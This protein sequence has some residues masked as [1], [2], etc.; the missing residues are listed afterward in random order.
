MWCNVSDGLPVW[1]N[2]GW[3]PGAVVLPTRDGKVLLVV[4]PAALWL[5]IVVVLSGAVFP[6]R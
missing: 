5:P 4:K 3:E 6:W 1:P 2:A